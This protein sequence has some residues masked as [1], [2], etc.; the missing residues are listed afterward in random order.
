MASQSKWLNWD[1]VS[2]VEGKKPQDSF[3]DVILVTK[4]IIFHELKLTIQIMNLLL[5]R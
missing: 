2:S 3:H 5:F 1:Q 4:I